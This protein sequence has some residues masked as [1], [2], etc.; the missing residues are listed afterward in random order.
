MEIIGNE[1]PITAH[2][3]QDLWELGATLFSLITHTLFWDQL[4]L[5]ID[6]LPKEDPDTFRLRAI[7]YYQEN[8][9]EFLSILNTVD[10]GLFIEF[11]PLV[12]GL[13]QIHPKK[14][15]T[16]EEAKE[17]VPVFT[18]KTAL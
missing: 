5:F 15:L 18:E 10:Y 8:P 16:L 3:S 4:S 13:L 2:P 9:L 17:L 11:K 7:S 6:K 14:R 12:I 1:K